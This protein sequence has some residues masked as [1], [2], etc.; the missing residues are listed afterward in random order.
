MDSFG[1]V[2]F[3]SRDISCME[4]LTSITIRST[5]KIKEI[6]NKESHDLK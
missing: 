5:K 6:E 2:K 1:T 3:G 4:S